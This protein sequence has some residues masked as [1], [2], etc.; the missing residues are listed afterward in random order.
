[1]EE[2]PLKSIPLGSCVQI[3]RCLSPLRSDV[4]R[5][6]EMGLCRGA[7]VTV[8][9]NDRLIGAIELALNNSRLCIANDL[10]NQFL[11]ITAQQS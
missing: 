7:R 5:L 6:L 9:Q 10:A 1:M 4:Y 11:T 8:L 3:T 2:K